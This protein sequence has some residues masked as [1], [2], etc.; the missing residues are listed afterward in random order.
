[1]TLAARR[2][3]IDVALDELGATSSSDLEATPYWLDPVGWA[4]DCL[5]F[6]HGKFLTDYQ[7]EEFNELIEYGRLAVISVRGAG[8]TMPAAVLILWFCV[9]REAAGVDWKCPTTAGS[10]DQLTHYLWPEVHKWASRIDWNRVG[11]LYGMTPWREGR[12]LQDRG[13]KLAHGESFA[14]ASNKPDLIEGAHAEHVLMVIDEGKSVPDATWDSV[15]GF[16]SVEGMEAFAFAISIP[17][18]PLGRL[19]DIHQRRPGTEIWHPKRVPLARAVAAG[20]VSQAWADRQKDLWGEKSPIYRQH[21]MAEFASSGTEGVIPLAWVEIANERWRELFGDRAK[22]RDSLMGTPQVLEAGEPVGAIGVDVASTGEDQSVLAFRIGNAIVE[23]RRFPY[24][25]DTMELAGYVVGAQRGHSIEG[26]SNRRDYPNAVIDSNGVGAGAFDRVREQ[27]LPVE[28]FVASAATKMKDMSGELGFTNKRSAAWWNLREMLDPDAGLDVALPPDDK[29]TAD[30][31]TPKWHLQSGGRIQVESKDDI[32]KRLSRSPDD[33]DAVVMAMWAERGQGA[34][35][36]AYW[37]RMVA[38]REGREPDASTPVPKGA[39]RRVRREVEN[40]GESGGA[41][42]AAAQ[43][44]AA[45]LAAK[46]GS[47]SRCSHPMFR[48]GSD[49]VGRCVRCGEADP[50]QT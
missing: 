45:R 3:W 18:E 4:R 44:H 42:Q 22:P 39:Q 47:S 6:P 26:A 38:D 15:E 31:V 17:A 40:A 20:Q 25:E 28:A 46:R 9:T 30:L 50:R 2:T 5:N 10:W 49:G 29:L 35:F 34:G 48:R 16:F 36:L 32:R 11:S 1:M 14:F 12:E 41:S 33:G 8:K 23:M 7:E 24:T 21:V 13:I 37:Q 43:R 27:R 19:Y